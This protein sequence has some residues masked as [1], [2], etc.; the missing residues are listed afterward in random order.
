MADHTPEAAISCTLAPQ[1]HG[2]VVV[3]AAAARRAGARWQ[4]GQRHRRRR[5]RRREA[6]TRRR[7]VTGDGWLAQG[8][9]PF[10]QLCSALD[11]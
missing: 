10:I 2:V 4:R 7:S 8:A 9:A 5:R 1:R 6:A 11:Q 3:R